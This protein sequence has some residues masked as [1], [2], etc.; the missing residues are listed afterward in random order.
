MSNLNGSES[1]YY[2]DVHVAERLT[3][4]TLEFIDKNHDKPFFVYLAHWEVHTPMAAKKDRIDYYKQKQ[5]EF[6]ED[7]FNPVYAAEVEQVDLSVGRIMDKIEQLNLDKNTIIIFTSDNGGLSAFT[8]N[9]PLRSGKGSFYEGGIRVPMC[10]TWPD[11]IK[12]GTSSGFP[13]SGIDFL[14]TFAEIASV[15]HPN[16][17]PVDG[18]SVLPILTGDDFEMKR[19]LFFHFPLYLEGSGLDK[20]LPIYN[21]EVDHWRAVPS[22]TVVHGKWKFI[23]YYEYETYELFNLYD[24]IGETTN[25]TSQHPELV[26]EFMISIKKWISEVDAPIPQIVNEKFRY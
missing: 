9:K 23:Y 8:A 5:K 16:N 24:D 14:P 15:P 20:V 12:P 17:Q 3:D 11:K 6:P 10:I 26:S 2:D 18:I 7:T 25:I 1:R 19:H 21:T 4:A 22:T 13:V